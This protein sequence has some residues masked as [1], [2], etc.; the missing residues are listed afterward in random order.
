[1]KTVTAAIL[2]RD[3]RVLL[4]RRAAGEKLAGKWE[5]PGGK[6]ESGE[7]PEECLRRELREELGIETRIRGFLGE[8]IYEYGHVAIRL[9][10]YETE[11]LAGDFKLTVHDDMKWVAVDDLLKQD[12]APADV[13][14]VKHIQEAPNV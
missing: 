4:T 1:M 6:L 2:W 7:T 11:Y 14:L 10:A 8:S 5:F 3:D 13:P 9:I 12:L